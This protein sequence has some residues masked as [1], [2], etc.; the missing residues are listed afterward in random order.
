MIWDNTDFFGGMFDFNGDGQTDFVEMALGF[1][2]LDE[3]R[4]EEDGDTDNDD[5]DTPDESNP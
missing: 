5:E 2:I 4:R 3:M 1:Q